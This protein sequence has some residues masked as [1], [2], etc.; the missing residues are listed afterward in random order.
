MS[1]RWLA[2]AGM[3]LTFTGC[4]GILVACW[5][6]DA[7]LATGIFAG[8]GAAL[9]ALFWWDT[10]RDDSRGSR[11]S[12]EVWDRVPSSAPPGARPRLDRTDDTGGPLSKGPPI[13]TGS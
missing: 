9:L 7:P 5:V 11:R 2:D 1:R 6:G 3:W 8:G 13:P 12:G 10:R 4:V